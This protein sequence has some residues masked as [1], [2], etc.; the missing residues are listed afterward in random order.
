MEVG[1][2]SS[3]AGTAVQASRQTQTQAVEQQQK[4]P[5]RPRQEEQQAPKPVKNAEGQTTG[6]VI[7]TT[8]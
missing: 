8:A 3:S 7:N 2:V 4:P 5:E 6:T 1:S